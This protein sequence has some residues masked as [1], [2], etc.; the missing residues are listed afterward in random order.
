METFT[1]RCKKA[2]LNSPCAEPVYIDLPGECNEKE[3]KCGKLNFWLY[4]FRPAAV[5]W[6]KHYSEKLVSEG[7][8]KGEGH[9]VVFYN[10]ERDVSV[11]IH[12]DDFMFCGVQENLEWVRDLMES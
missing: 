11:V 1:Y 5:S 7:F 8:V 12:G 2:H 6:E 4:G 3:G 9:G 10:K